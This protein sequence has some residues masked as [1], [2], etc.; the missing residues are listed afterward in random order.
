M[1]FIE[2]NVIRSTKC[3]LTWIK[4][5]FL[6]IL[7][8]ISLTLP[9]KWIF[10]ALFSLFHLLLHLRAVSVLQSLIPDIKVNQ[11]VV[12]ELHAEELQ[13]SGDDENL[14]TS[15][16]DQDKGLK[17]RRTVTQVRKGIQYHIQV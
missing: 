11:E 10:I 15:Q 8:Y 16:V 13:M 5:C 9:V 14:D 3:T 7:Q 2:V 12:V 17:I 6:N 4:T 1:I